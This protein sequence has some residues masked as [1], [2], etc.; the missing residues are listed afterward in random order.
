MF[1]APCQHPGQ[2]EL[3]LDGRLSVLRFVEPLV[4]Q[5]SELAFLGPVGDPS[6]RP[7]VEACNVDLVLRTRDDPYQLHV[8]HPVDLQNGVDGDEASGL[9][10]GHD[11]LQQCHVPPAIGQQEVLRGGGEP[12]GS[13]AVRG[14]DRPGVEDLPKGLLL[15][16]VDA[17]LVEQ[18]GHRPQRGVVDDHV[19][20]RVAGDAGGEVPAAGGEVGPHLAAQ[21]GVL[22]LQG[23]PLQQLCRIV[24]VKVPDPE[25]DGAGHVLGH[26]RGG[27]GGCGCR[28]LRRVGVLRLRVRIVPL[29]EVG[30]E[31][32]GQPLPPSP[33]RV[34]RRSCPRTSLLDLRHRGARL[35]GVGRLQV[36]DVAKGLG[37]GGLR[38]PRL[39]AAPAALLLLGAYHARVVVVQ[40]VPPPHRAVRLRQ[41]LRGVLVVHLSREQ[42]GPPKGVK[43][44]RPEGPLRPQDRNGLGPAQVALAVV[45]DVQLVPRGDADDLPE[46]VEGKRRDG[47][48]ELVRRDALRGLG[49]PDPHLV[50]EGPARQHVARP[51]VKGNHP[52]GPPVPRQDVQTLPRAA[53]D[54]L[55]SVVPVRRGEDLTVRAEGRSDRGAGRGLELAVE[56]RE[57]L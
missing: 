30:P 1:V 15:H 16:R 10:V 4:P 26:S 52:G 35:S 7:R 54:D 24:D 6:A 31:D 12:D 36:R 51:R 23:L 27:R 34:P 48:A 11:T 19:R 18:G 38:L 40:G 32:A 8:R 49:V 5:Q 45:P 21:H 22:D 42:D 46:R 17:E 29:R 3:V 53:A 44:D 39:A 20:R 56:P 28:R 43:V 47:L 13:E 25:P 33:R 41:V 55:H 50:V 37:L 14:P 2:Q 57:R 9:R